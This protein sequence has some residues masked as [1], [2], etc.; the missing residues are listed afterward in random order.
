MN[1]QNYHC[2]MY[3]QNA[4]EKDEK[5]E[6]P[7]LQEKRKTDSNEHEQNLDN[8]QTTGFLFGTYR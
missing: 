4:I 3:S 5:D 2:N 1:V 6:R 7:H 8:H